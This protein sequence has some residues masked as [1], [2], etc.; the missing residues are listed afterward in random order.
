MSLLP[1]SDAMGPVTE[2]NTAAGDEDK[3]GPIGG[4]GWGRARSGADP[5]D[6]NATTGGSLYSI[7]SQ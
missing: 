2:E 3:G 5:S 7:L 6:R 4:G 1:V